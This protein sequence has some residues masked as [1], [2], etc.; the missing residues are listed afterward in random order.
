MFLTVFCLFVFSGFCFGQWSQWPWVRIPGH[1]AEQVVARNLA[2]VDRLTWIGTPYY[3]YGYYGYL[4]YPYGYGIPNLGRLGR[5]A[6]PALAGFAIGRGISR[7]DWGTFGAGAAA[8]GI[9]LID[10][11]G[12]RKQVKEVRLIEAEPEQVY[13]KKEK[14]VAGPPAVPP[15]PQLEELWDIENVSGFRASLYDGKELIVVFEDGDRKLVPPPRSGNYNVRAR[16]PVKGG[17]IWE[18][19]AELQSSEDGRGW[20]IILPNGGE[21]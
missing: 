14:A 19:P 9:W 10:E 16:I 4:G 6:I 3:P 11:L 13:I 21:K 17:R 18:A 2:L 1:E 7:R 5:V 15:V 8:A 20:K 12:R